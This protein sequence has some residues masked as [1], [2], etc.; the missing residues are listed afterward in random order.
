M[1]RYVVERTFPDG[2]NIPVDAQGAATCLAVVDRNAD[3]GVT[4]VHSYVSDD[5]TKTFCIYDA[6]SP[7]AIRK[8][9]DRNSLPVDQITQVS[10]LDPYFYR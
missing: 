7:E 1:P 10:V 8:T 2:L 3:D 5:K 4:W 6:P 9:A